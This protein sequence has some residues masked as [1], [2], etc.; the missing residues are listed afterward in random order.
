MKRL[1]EQLGQ[2]IIDI[3]SLFYPLAKRFLSLETYLYGFT[4]GINMMLDLILYFLVYNYVLD[5][6]IVDLGIVSVSAYI[7]AFIIVFPITFSIGF[8]LAK[9]VTFTQS[10]LKGKKQLFRYGVSVSGSI[11]LNYLLLKL[12]VGV[13]DIYPTPSKLITTIVVVAYSFLIQKFFTFKTGKKQ[14][15][16]D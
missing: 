9:F 3:L 2:K 14:L 10:N 1:A 12:F 13:F 7:A 11:L 16:K 5:K 8:F 4:G 15:L 6:Q